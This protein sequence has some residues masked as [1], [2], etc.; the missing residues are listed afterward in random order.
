MWRVE[1]KLKLRITLVI[2]QMGELFTN[3]KYARNRGGI[4]VVGVQWWGLIMSS[5]WDLLGWRY[6]R[7]CE[8]R[9]YDDK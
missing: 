1:Q 5:V 7:T 8:S 9:N 6:L 3:R 4:S 2:G